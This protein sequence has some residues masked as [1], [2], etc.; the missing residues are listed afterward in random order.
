MNALD[1]GHLV[2]RYRIL[3][4]LGAGAMGEVYLAED[5]QI[6]RRLAIKTVRL[7]G[8]PQE[9]EDRK[10]RLLREARAA[11]RLLHP[12][13]V[14][15]FDAGEAEGLLY[16]A[17]EFVEGTDLAARL[18]PEQQRLSLRQ[19]LR[20]VRHAAEALDYAH[21]Q[22]I[23]HRDIKPSNI[24][25]DL[26][27]RVKVADFGIAKMAGQST[28]LTMA[29]SV[30]GSPQYL[31]PEQIRGDDLDGRSDIFSLGVVFYEMLSGK[32]PFEGDTITTLVYQILHK[33]P[34]PVSELRAVPPRVEALLRGMLAKSRD[35]RIPTAGEV[36]RELAAIEAELSDET[37]SAP[38]GTG[39]L[40]ATRVLPKR[41]TD[42]P[43]LPA[44]IAEARPALGTVP[45]SPET[46]P[47]VPPPAPTVA[48]PIP[49]ASMP[50]APV[51]AVPMAT[52]PPPPAPGRRLPMALLVA[53]LLLL[54]AV[55]GIAGGG[56]YVWKLWQMRNASSEPAAQ[57]AEA[58]QAAPAPVQ[59][60]SGPASVP[61]SP[62]PVQP[63]PEAKETK[64]P[65]QTSPI[66]SQAP[67]PATRP[68][69]TEKAPAPAPSSAPPAVPPPARPREQ[70]VP[71][72]AAS[73]PAA[74][75]PAPAPAPREPEPEAAPEE[76]AADQTIRTG[77]Q[78]SFRVTPPDA[79]VLVEGKVIGQAQE[80]SGQ[81][82]ARPYTFPGPGTY[83][84]KIK[85]DGMKERRIAVEAG[86]G[87]S[88][89]I[90]AHLQALAAA[91]VDTSDLETVR[92]REGVALNVR[93]GN[94][95]VL[96]DGQ[97][98]GEAR[99]YAGGLLRPREILVL[100][101]GKHRLSFVAPGY[102]RKDV[103]VV[104]IETADKQR[105][106]INVDLTAGGNGG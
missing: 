24:L 72:P 51:P 100:N 35:E 39:P 56:Y 95:Q 52:M 30:M 15:L 16:L 5:P 80:W 65:Q 94:A 71:G 106:R 49:T 19:V 12:N 73:E 91:D 97:P 59:P 76:P 70:R 18:D 93:P 104:V 9:I 74:P 4:F 88:S 23:V 21:G 53:G 87:G 50:A 10:R 89:V 48:A 68:A 22:G 41:T 78:V 25:L 81:K 96:V 43:I 11:G 66:T 102:A 7:V 55:G 20:I 47:S 92:V 90:P 36:A 85:K 42:A 64:A 3:S 79:Y 63:A 32:R 99:R 46:T 84:V 105:Q 17:F 2:G 27:G 44:G 45:A 69:P 26:A 33:D 57:T 67:A 75:V 61:V 6:D 14:T 62:A 34:P 31:S 38:A 54:V 60:V 29:G 28:E 37:L 58:S 13:V 40:D 86:A 82:G 77:L 98:V 101:P 1:G 83:M 8:R 103:E